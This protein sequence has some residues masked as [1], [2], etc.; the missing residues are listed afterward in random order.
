MA[1]Q[2]PIGS[3]CVTRGTPAQYARSYAPRSVGQ[4]DRPRAAPCKTQPPRRE[5]PQGPYGRSRGKADLVF[6]SLSLVL[7]HPIRSDYER[8]L[9]VA[10]EVFAPLHVAFFVEDE[11]HAD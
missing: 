11:F 4:V 3:L 8:Q 6:V 5:V 9:D 7:M 2:R 10:N 1:G